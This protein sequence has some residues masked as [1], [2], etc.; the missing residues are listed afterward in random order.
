MG[1]SSPPVDLSKYVTKTEY[2]DLSTLLKKNLDDYTKTPD[3]EK[4]FVK[5][6]DLAGYAKTTDI[7]TEYVRATGNLEKTFVKP[8]DLAE[9]VKG[10]DLAGYAKTTELANYLK[11]SDLGGYAKTTDLA[12]YIK[13]SDLDTSA[14][15]KVSDLKNIQADLEKYRIDTDD[16]V[17][18][19]MKNQ[20]MFCVD[21]F[22]KTPNGFGIGPSSS[23]AN[24]NC[25]FKGDTPLFCIDTN[26][27]IVSGTKPLNVSP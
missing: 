16:N 6:T 22:C 26:N 1:N 10:T 19:T 15:A 12:G 4:T 21:G 13:A 2:N 14:F 8:I 5:T 9:Y 27:N 20:G 3:L 17:K 23:N 18:T 25:I 24:I 7:A 11:A